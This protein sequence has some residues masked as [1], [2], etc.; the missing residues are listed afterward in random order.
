MGYFGGLQSKWQQYH[1]PPSQITAKYG[2]NT[3]K[4]FEAAA[5]EPQE[6]VLNADYRLTNIINFWKEK[7]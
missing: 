6:S 3:A 5:A 4:Y 2:R 1:T 7:L